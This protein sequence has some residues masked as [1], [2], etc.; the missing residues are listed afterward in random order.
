MTQRW[1]VKSP[2]KR[3]DKTYWQRVGTMFADDKGGF[4]IEFDSLPLPDEEG[5]VR[6]KAWEPKPKPDQQYSNASMGGEA[7]DEIPF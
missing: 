4:S 3:K 5:R 1:D 7:D 2:R 6:C